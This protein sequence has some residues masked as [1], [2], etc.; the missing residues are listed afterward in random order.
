V[1]VAGVNRVCDLFEV[2]E[3]KITVVFDKHSLHDLK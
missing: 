1:G 2:I 3:T